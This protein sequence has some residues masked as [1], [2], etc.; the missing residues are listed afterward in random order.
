MGSVKAFLPLL[1]YSHFFSS[2]I[3]NAPAVG[4]GYH[5][6]LAGIRWSPFGAERA[7]NRA[8]VGQLSSGALHLA[9]LSMS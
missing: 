1:L 4:G 5:A 2:E 8:S 9:S 3:R 6:I 7:K